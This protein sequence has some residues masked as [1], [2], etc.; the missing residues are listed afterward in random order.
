[1]AAT[2]QAMSHYLELENFRE[3][4]KNSG[5]PITI[6]E[7]R[8]QAD[9]IVA[10]MRECRALLDDP[11]VVDKEAIPKITEQHLNELD[12]WNTIAALL[13]K[14]EPTSS[15]IEV[16][17]FTYTGKEK[18]I[19]S[20]QKFA[21]GGQLDWPSWKERLVSYLKLCNYRQK[22]AVIMANWALEPSTQSMVD[23]ITLDTYTEMPDGNGLWRLLDEY[24]KIFMAGTDT[25]VPLAQFGQTT[26]GR[27]DLQV[28]HAKLRSLY[29][30][31]YPKLSAQE[32]NQNQEL[33]QKFMDGL[34]SGKVREHVVRGRGRT[35]STYEELLTAAL[36]EQATQV[37][38]HL[39]TAASQASLQAGAT[40]AQL[41]RQQEGVFL[42]AAPRPM[43]RQQP[44][45]IVQPQPAPE[46]ME[47]GALTTEKCKFCPEKD[48]PGYKGHTVDNCWK[49][50]KAM[51]NFGN[52]Q[53]QYRP[54]APRFI[55]PQRPNFTPR[56]GFPRYQGPRAPFR[57]GQRTYGPP[58]GRPF[59]R[60]ITAAILD[61]LEQGINPEDTL[62]YH[63][64]SLEIQDESPQEEDPEGEGHEQ[65]EAT[66]MNYTHDHAPEDFTED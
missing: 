37:N 14:D 64:A 15:M 57:S 66:E 44:Q 41:V 43:A 2:Q 36:H 28:F 9:K 34:I 17:G 56:S 58:R 47:I 27:M 31:A 60:Q 33:C 53:Y 26:Q 55:P 20:P 50:E 23:H 12:K 8:L 49:V 62:N 7:L 21:M 13:I 24:A 46:P 42:P 6:A 39:N 30:Q 52:Q 25:G 18:S 61:D 40:T 45:R 35:W 19:H 63:L 38:T 51:R 59:K 54:Q 16:E 4:L 3:Q 22:T 48:R 11:T 10:L 65:A 1:M 29:R 32:L 5:R